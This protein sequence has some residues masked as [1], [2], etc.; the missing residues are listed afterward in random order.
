MNKKSLLYTNTF[1]HSSNI[2]DIMSEISAVFCAL[3]N[4]ACLNIDNRTCQHFRC[5]G[6]S[7]SFH[8]Y[9]QCV[10]LCIPKQVS[11]EFPL[12]MTSTLLK[13]I[14]RFFT[15]Q[16]I[17]NTLYDSLYSGLDI[18]LAMRQQYQGHVFN[19]QGAHADKT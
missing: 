5:F 3:K 19:S 17:L 13:F 7:L 8:Y 12:V 15:Q 16:S 2:H 1:L 11:S 4:N 9:A 10:Y 14:R 18:E 6:F